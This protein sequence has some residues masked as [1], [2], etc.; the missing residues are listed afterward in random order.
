MAARPL[1]PC[2]TPAMAGTATGRGMAYCS[3]PALVAA[4]PLPGAQRRSPRGRGGCGEARRAASGPGTMDSRPAHTRT[5]RRATATGRGSTRQARHWSG[6]TTGAC[7]AL[8][9][10]SASVTD[11]NARSSPHGSARPCTGAQRW[12]RRNPPSRAARRIAFARPVGILAADDGRHGVRPRDE[13]RLRCKRSA[14]K[15]PWQFRPPRT[16]K[17]ASRFSRGYVDQV[18]RCRVTVPQ[19]LP[20]T[21]PSLAACSSCPS[22]L[23]GSLDAPRPARR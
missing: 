6:R 8:R 11:A 7:A 20:V 5:S 12:C 13:Q 3:T 21:A 4:E 19:H 18:I 10:L 1:P 16:A 14:W 2:P 23:R 15:N 17:T 22:S 9:R